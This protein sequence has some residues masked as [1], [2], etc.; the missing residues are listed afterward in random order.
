MGLLDKVL[1]NA[2]EV[3]KDRLEQELAPILT[4]GEEVISGFVVWRDVFAFTSKRLVVIDKQGVTGKKREYMSIPFRSIDAFAAETA[5]TLDRDSE[6][7]LWIR[8]QGMVKYEIK[9]G[10]DIRGLCKQ[11]GEFVL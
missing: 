9:K 10:Y 2:T 11:L 4:E 6:L 5:G 1:G 3:N 7:K 8:G